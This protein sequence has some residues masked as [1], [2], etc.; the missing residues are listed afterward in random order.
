VDALDESDDGI[1]LAEVF[2]NIIIAV[3]LKQVEIIYTSQPESDIERISNTMTKIF[4]EEA[5]T[6]PDVDLFIADS[7]G[8]SEVLEYYEDEAKRSLI[9]RPIGKAGNVFLYAKLVI[10]DFEEHHAADDI[11]GMFNTLPKI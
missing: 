2:S 1:S 4:I 10:H 3:S 9:R 7:I 8:N 5:D 11:G 6:R